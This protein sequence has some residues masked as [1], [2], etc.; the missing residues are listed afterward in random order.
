M[1]GQRR[2]R[3]AI[4]GAGLMG[5]WHAAAVARAGHIVGAVIDPDGTRAAALATRYPGAAIAS[6]LEGMTAV[7]VVHVCSPL[8]THLPLSQ[9]ALTRGCH[10]VVEKPLAPTA[11]DTRALLTL[12]EANGRLIVPVHQFLFQRGVRQALTAIDTIGPLLH[13]DFSICTA[14]A[15]HLAVSERDQVVAEILPHPLSLTAR[16]IST[17][18]ADTDWHVRQARPGELRAVAVLDDTSVSILI[19]TGGRPT[20]NAMRALGAR[21]TVHVDLFHGFAVVT[22]GRTTRAG[23]LLQPFVT[24]GSMM[25]AGAV[26]LGR[27]VAAREAAYPGLWQLIADFYRAAITGGSAPIS[28]DECYAVA[29]AMDRIRNAE[30]AS[31][32]GVSPA[33]F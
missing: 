33:R 17:A 30:R 5:R 16:L 20:V 21:G 25:A 19:S 23:K 12:A 32:A 29:V 14:G 15:S 31:T 3:A 26:N 11:G 13:L 7:D 9:E 2:L 8:P 6:S 28:T 10:V 4:V 1:S 24:A 22:R 27:R 18:I